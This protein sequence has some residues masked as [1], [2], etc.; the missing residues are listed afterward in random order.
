MYV[1][2]YVCILWYAGMVGQA[3]GLCGEGEPTRDR[4]TDRQIETE[5]ERERETESLAHPQLP[6]SSIYPFVFLWL[7]S[8]LVTTNNLQL[9]LLMYVC[10]YV[11]QLMSPCMP[12]AALGVQGL[13]DLGFRFRVRGLRF[14]VQRVYGSG[15]G[16]RG[17]RVPV[18]GLGV[19]GSSLGFRGFRVR[20]YGLGLGSCLGFRGF[21][22]QVQGL[23]AMFDKHIHPYV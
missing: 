22:V 18:Q 6:L 13:E 3:Q 8:Q 14:T 1:C 11:C 21:R 20:V 7:F 15:L 10:M 2:M 19:Q 9:S 5:R 4:Q 17:F 23:V 12:R 16:F